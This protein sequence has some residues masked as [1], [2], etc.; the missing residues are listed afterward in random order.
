MWKI[1]GSG[2]LDIVYPAHT[3]HDSG[4]FI[5]DLGKMVLISENQA[6]H[7]VHFDFKLSG[8]V[9]T[10]ARATIFDF[11]NDGFDEA[12]TFKVR[13]ARSTL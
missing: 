12:A 10:V 1:T 13:L 6:Y 5:V 2:W 7:P 3:D 9:L 4:V 8:N 11:D